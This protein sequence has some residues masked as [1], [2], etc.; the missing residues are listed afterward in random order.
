[1]TFD[2]GQQ[3]DD[4][5]RSLTSV[6]ITKE[7]LLTGFDEILK[8]QKSIMM[9]TY[10]IGAIM[11]VAILFNTLMM[12]LAERDN[13]LATL[14]VLGASIKD[15]AVILTIEHAFIG[16]VGGIAGVATSILMF[17]GMAS[18]F[19]TWQ[20][21]MPVTIDSIV[22]LK[23]LSFILIAS[24]ATTPF[25]MWRIRKMDLLDVVSRHQN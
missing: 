3:L 25:G 6:V 20:F 4:D 23:V 1:M 22:A 19:S 17:Q 10:M 11:A 14:R 12:N 16:L 8:Q 9:T 7:D 15:L 13:E 21:F 18:A 24:L 5:V 2:E